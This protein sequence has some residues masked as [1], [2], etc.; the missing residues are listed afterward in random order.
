MAKDAIMSTD[1][2][3]SNS[4]PKDANPEFEGEGSYS[5]A[6]QYQ[7]AQHEFAE[8]GPVEEKAREAADALD[9]NE[10]DELEEARKKAAQG[11]SV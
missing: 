1:T 2:P 11:D 4:D 6:K 5:G 3:Q 10:A 7:D 8:H 9:S